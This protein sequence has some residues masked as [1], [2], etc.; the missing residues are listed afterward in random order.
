MLVRRFP[1][2]AWLLLCLAL[3][4]AGLVLR[5]AAGAIPPDAA[6][7]DVAVIAA[8]PA[9]PTP[10]AIFRYDPTTAQTVAAEFDRAVAAARGAFRAELARALGPE[11][12]NTAA[13]AGPSFDFIFSDWAARWRGFPAKPDVARAWAQGQDGARLVRPLRDR[14]VQVMTEHRV[15][16]SV[17]DPEELQGPVEVQIVPLDPADG[18]LTLERVTAAAQLFR[19]PRLYSLAQARQEV[20][21]GWPREDWAAARFAAELVRP[22]TFFAAALTR[23]ARRLALA[24]IRQPET[25]PV[26]LQ[27]PEPAPAALRAAPPGSAAVETPAGWRQWLFLA[28]IPA[29][30]CAGAIWLAAVVARERSGAAPG[31]MPG[32]EFPRLTSLE[33]RLAR[34]EPQLRG[35]VDELESRIRRLEEKLPGAHR[36]DRAALRRE[37]FEVRL[38]RDGELTRLGLDR[39]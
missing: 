37:L 23:E 19:R 26:R 9:D 15:R 8:P 16:E 29:G 6:E 21:G 25:L 1:P 17:T 33:Q 14:L 30:L 18:S 13:L 24:G 12:W 35:R 34:L 22:N 2:S 7:P 38:E 39:N 28:V 27:L 32:P 20:R 36:E 3:G 4:G 11:P 5:G 31:R 10:A